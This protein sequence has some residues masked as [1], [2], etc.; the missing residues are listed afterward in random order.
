MDVLLE[1]GGFNRCRRCRHGNM[2]YN[3]NDVYI[4]RSLD[5]YGEWAE[6]ELALLGLLLEPADIVVDVG[7]NVGT[8]TVF[9]AASVGRHGKVFAFEPQRIV[10]QALC[11]NLA[12]NGLANVHAIPAAAARQPG[13]I[14]VPALDYE[15]PLNF[16]GV[17]LA[18][19]GAGE[20]V[21]TMTLD[22]L[23]IDRC[24]LLKIDVEGM[25]LEVLEGARTL[26]D[27]FKPIIYMENNNA[28]KSP[29]LIQ[30]LE[31]AGYDLFWHFSR[32]FNPANF[33]NRAE[34]V[35]GGIADVN[36]ICVRP[37]LAPAFAS[38][39]RVEGAGDTGEA[40]LLR[41]EGRA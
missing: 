33:F 6:A 10:F 30:A 16:G 32:F 31:E 35:F 4:G 14:V 36:M 29:A 26:I 38:F 27:T 22:E 8:H 41:R 13:T 5:L 34:N 17:G 3:V 1:T 39:Q 12:L 20:R 23:P 21:P 9:F 24:K 11:A 25:E 7:A 19:N 40:A 18:A 15:S 28:R 37:E 2:L